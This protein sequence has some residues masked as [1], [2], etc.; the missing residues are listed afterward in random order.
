MPH[1]CYTP[2]DFVTPFSDGSAECASPIDLAARCH[3]FPSDTRTIVGND[4]I[5]NHPEAARPEFG[6][7][8][9]RS[10]LVSFDSPNPLRLFKIEHKL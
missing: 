4:S 9:R 3:W 1:R 5:A 10:H 6:R 7:K 2:D 8:F